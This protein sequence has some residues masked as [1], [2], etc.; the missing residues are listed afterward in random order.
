MLR[1]EY[2]FFQSKFKL[3]PALARLHFL[4]MRPSNFPTVRLAQLAILIHQSQNLFSRIL[5][6]EQLSVIKEMFSVTANDYWHYH[7]VFD[8][9]SS[10]KPKHLGEDMVNNI[11]INTVS[12]SLFAYGKYHNNDNQKEKAVRWL[13][14]IQAENNAI[15][16]GF[17]QLGIP[18]A[19]A[20]DSQS[21][22]QLKNEYCN[23]FRCLDC[24][25]GNWLLRKDSI[26]V[27]V[28]S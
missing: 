8:E 26:T 25:V 9:E 19:S 21:L 17:S 12:P 11:L 23:Q 27:N 7:Y 10:Y 5:E 3:R 28:N 13:M 15:I 20:F 1:K 18:V 22:I 14:E 2:K 4:R 16:K 24:A 6:T